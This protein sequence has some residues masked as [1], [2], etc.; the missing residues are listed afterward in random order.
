[1]L[2]P[3]AVILALKIAVVLVTARLI[4]SLLAL[5]ARRPKWHGRINTVFFAL[6]A[7][8]VVGFE[9]VIRLLRPT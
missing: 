5:A 4:A 8:T 9:A 6:T 1:M 3:G 2:T 7:I